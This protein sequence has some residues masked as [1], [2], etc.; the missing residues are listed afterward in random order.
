MDTL[1]KSNLLCLCR[2]IQLV[3]SD[4]HEQVKACAR[5]RGRSALITWVWLR[6]SVV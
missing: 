2:A 6:P 3:N 4:A 5:N 1:E